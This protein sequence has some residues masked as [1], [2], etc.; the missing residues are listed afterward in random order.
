MPRPLPIKTT[1][2]ALDLNAYLMA[3]RARIRKLSD[4]RLHIPSEPQHIEMHN[5]WCVNRPGSTLVIPVADVARH[6]L[7][8]FCYLVQNGA[9]FYDDIHKSPVPGI[10]RFKDLVDIDNPYPLSFLEQLA[11]TETTVEIATSCYAGMLTLQALGLGG[12]MFDGISPLSVLGASGDPD[13]PGLG[14]RFDKDDRWGLPNVTGLAGVFEGHCPPHYP[15]MRAAVE[16]V[17]ERKFGPGGPFHPDTPGPYR[18]NPKIRAGAETH[19]PQFIDC[20]TTMADYVY[21]RFGKF[22]GTVPT[23]FVLMFLQA[24]HLELGFYDKYCGPGAY[25]DT[26]T[27]HMERWHA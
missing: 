25:L 19:S 1:R 9:C 22:P 27:H 11:L 17:V 4:K 18:D 14:F 6:H 8:S 3:H 26:H 5:P 24:H 15:N 21:N 2:G 20:V 12:W 13:V 7:A 16:A 23:I 10:E